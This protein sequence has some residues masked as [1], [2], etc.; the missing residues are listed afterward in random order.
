MARPWEME[1]QLPEVPILP[2][3]SFLSAPQLPSRCPSVALSETTTLRP[4]AL[5]PRASAS[6]KRPSFIS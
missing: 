1:M 3:F 5:S 4:P 6:H 2:V